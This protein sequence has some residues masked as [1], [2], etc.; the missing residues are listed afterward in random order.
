MRH[1]RIQPNPKK[2]NLIIFH[3]NIKNN[4]PGIKIG[5]DTIRPT[6]E[7]KYLGIHVDNKLNFKHHMKV[8]KKAAITR[9]G[10]FR[11]LTYKNLGIN[12][13]TA[14]SIYKMICRPLLDYGG[15]IFSNATKT[16]LN[17]LEIAERTCLRKITKLRH[18][19]NPLHNPSN[20]LLYETTEVEPILTRLH[21]LGMKFIKNQNNRNIME[22]LVHRYN[23]ET[24]EKA[25][26]PA[27][28]LYEHLLSLE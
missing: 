10:H 24:T 20:T 25:K 1:W 18:P 14:S 22:P 3:H 8:Q 15:I 11:S 17:N 21:R 12:I 28:P 16:C 6:T 4:S 13:K 9:A 2:S 7:C 26:L 27:L 5:N 23:R 19:N